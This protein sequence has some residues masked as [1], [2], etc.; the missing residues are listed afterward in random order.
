MKG[1]PQNK[2]TRKIIPHYN[3]DGNI[4]GVNVFDN[5]ENSEFI[6]VLCLAVSIAHSSSAEDEQNM[7]GKDLPIYCRSIPRTR[8]AHC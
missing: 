4:D 5:S 7:D 1:I 2:R 6:P 3:I 8:E